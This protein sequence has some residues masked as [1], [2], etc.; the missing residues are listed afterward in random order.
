MNSMHGIATA[1]CTPQQQIHVPYAA[2]IMKWHDSVAATSQLSHSFR[3]LSPC[4]SLRVHDLML[5][6]YS[7]L[8]SV[9]LQCSH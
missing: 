9:V 8:G 1:S 6:V 7:A 3:P 4:V 5:G 2:I